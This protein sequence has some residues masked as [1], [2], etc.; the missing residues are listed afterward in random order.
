M[1]VKVCN[2]STNP[3]MGTDTAVLEN[4]SLHAEFNSVSNVD[5]TKMNLVSVSG[6]FFSLFIKSQLVVDS[7]CLGHH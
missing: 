1:Q 3:H 5:V 2:S 4:T 7:S 6:C